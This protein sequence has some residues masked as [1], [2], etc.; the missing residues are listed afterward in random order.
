MVC[1]QTLPD[2]PS[3]SRPTLNNLLRG[4]LFSCAEDFDKKT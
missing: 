4:V 2:F 1:T 3:G